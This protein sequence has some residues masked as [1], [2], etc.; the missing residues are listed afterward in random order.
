MLRYTYLTCLFLALSFIAWG[1]TPVKQAKPKQV[2]HT[3]T[4]T[5]SVRPFDKA[6]LVNYASQKEF[7]YTNG[8]VGESLWTRFWRWFWGLF[9]NDDRGTIA[10]IFVTILEYLLIGFGIAALV[11]LIMKLIGIDALNVIRRRAKATPLPY[12][13]S[14]E[15]IYAIDFD[16]EIEKA[17]GQQNYRLAVRLLYLRSLRQLADAGLINW[18]LTKTNSIYVDELT[19]AEQQIAFKLLTRQFEYVW[20]GEFMIDA[21]VF[22]KISALFNDFKTMRA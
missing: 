12:D 9:N 3:D 5:V 18:D 8:Y 21:P 7:K 11:F 15:N 10:S 19:N 17:I 13:E 20:Y 4:T 6:A 1:G 16:A 14:T 2:V 22:K